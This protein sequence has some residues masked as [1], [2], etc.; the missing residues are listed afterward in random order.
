MFHRNNVQATRKVV[1][2]MNFKFKIR[3]SN[4]GREITKGGKRMFVR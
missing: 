1:A 2:E 4:D 3:K